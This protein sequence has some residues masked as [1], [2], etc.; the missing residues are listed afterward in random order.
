MALLQRSSN[1]AGEL[2]RRIQENESLLLKDR[3]FEVP[4]LTE[5]LRRW[6]AGEQPKIKEGDCKKGPSDQGETEAKRRRVVPDEDV[7]TALRQFGNIFGRREQFR[8]VGIR[9]LVSSGEPAVLTKPL[10]EMLHRHDLVMEDLASFLHDRKL[11]QHFSPLSAPSEEI[12]EAAPS[13][14]QVEG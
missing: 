12:Q 2:R 14:E 13:P 6:E 4:V 5:A 7:A 9:A 3:V 8:D 1:I 11:R 10:N